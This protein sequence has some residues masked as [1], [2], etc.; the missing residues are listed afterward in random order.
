MVVV[1]AEILGG[2]EQT[3]PV[4]HKFEGGRFEMTLPD[5]PIVVDDGLEFYLRLELFEADSVK[6][7]REWDFFWDEFLLERSTAIVNFLTAWKERFPKI[8]EA[9]FRDLPE[10]KDRWSVEIPDL[11]LS[12]ILMR[13]HLTT[14]EEFFEAIDNKI[15]PEEE[16]E[17]DSE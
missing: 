9:F 6:D 17:E 2:L 3:F 1:S 8:V 16:D 10:D 14:K 5:R 12:R 15:E 7:A 11:F 13:E 4:T